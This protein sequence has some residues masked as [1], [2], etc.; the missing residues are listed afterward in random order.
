MLIEQKNDPFAAMT[1]QMALVV[2]A[3]NYALYRVLSTHPLP[4][5]DWRQPNPSDSS[6]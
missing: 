6:H 2:K 5:A 3:S 1:G 4:D